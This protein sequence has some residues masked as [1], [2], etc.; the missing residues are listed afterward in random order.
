M[1]VESASSRIAARVQQPFQRKVVHVVHGKQAVG[2]VI[3]RAAGG[4]KAFGQRAK[5]I[6]Q[7]VALRQAMLDSNAAGGGVN[8]IDFAMPGDGAKTIAPVSSLPA[9]VK[10]VL[11]DGFSQP[12]YSGMPLIEIT[13]SQAGGTDGLTITCSNVTVRGLEIDNFEDGAGILITGSAISF[14]VRP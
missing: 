12:G 11:I 7:I 4:F 9:I 2:D 10:P 13:G 5:N 3:E 1:P 14:I 8:T 6:R